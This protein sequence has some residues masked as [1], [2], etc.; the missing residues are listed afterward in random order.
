[1]RIDLHC[2]TKKQKEEILILEMLLQ[3][4]LKRKYLTAMSK[5]LE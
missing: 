4:Y 3:N 1:M 5:L 2:H